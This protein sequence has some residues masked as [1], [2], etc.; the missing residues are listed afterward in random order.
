MKVVAPVAAE[1]GLRLLTV[2][3]G[4]AREFNRT[5]DIRLRFLDIGIDLV[6][7]RPLHGQAEASDEV[8]GRR[9]RQVLER[10]RPSLTLVLEGD[11]AA[12][13]AAAAAGELGVRTVAFVRSEDGEDAQALR[14]AN[15]ETRVHL[16]GNLDGSD[17]GR[18][19]IEILVAERAGS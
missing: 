19:L 9:V 2:L 4:A 15:P 12:R 5:L 10:E 1:S 7:V 6:P 14:E 8:W 16:L 17:E 3:E 11:P 13:A 18:R